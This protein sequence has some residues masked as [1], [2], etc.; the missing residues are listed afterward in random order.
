[1]NKK[2]KDMKQLDKWAIV[3][4]LES[5]RTATA[6]KRGHIDWSDLASALEHINMV[7]G[8]MISSGESCGYLLP[9]YGLYCTPGVVPQEQLDK[10][11]SLDV[12]S[13]SQWNSAIHHTVPFEVESDI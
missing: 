9:H 11:V 5:G 4:T 7:R 2:D 1:M 8:L 6:S 12:V 3:Q 10:V 13:E